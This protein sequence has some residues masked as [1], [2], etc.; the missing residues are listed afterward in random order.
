M[1]RPEGWETE[2]SQ[3]IYRNISRELSERYD[4]DEAKLGRDF[5]I[6]GFEAG[7]DAI[8]EALRKDPHAEHL[9]PYQ[10][11]QSHATI[12]GTFVFIPDK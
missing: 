5:Y 4:K 6:R 11:F 1:W 7:A 10:N 8:L 9:E 3:I 12:P 2:A